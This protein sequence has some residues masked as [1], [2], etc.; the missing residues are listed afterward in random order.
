MTTIV[1]GLK[2][3]ITVTEL[4]ESMRLNLKLC[5]KNYKNPHFSETDQKFY[6]GASFVLKNL[7]QD[8]FNN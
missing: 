1:R 6:H 2:Q 8:Y 4:E 3:N 5:E 7:I